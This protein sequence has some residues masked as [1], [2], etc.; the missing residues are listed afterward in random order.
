MRALTELATAGAETK[1]QDTP[2]PVKSRAGLFLPYHRH[3]RVSSI[4]PPPEGDC[5]D[6]DRQGY[7]FQGFNRNGFHRETGTGSTRV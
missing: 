5:E 6:Y 3:P 2:R 7:D 4:T 1:Q